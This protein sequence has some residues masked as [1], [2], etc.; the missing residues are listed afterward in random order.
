V[1]VLHLFLPMPSFTDA[2]MPL[3]PAA[4]IQTGE[5]DHTL[6]SHLS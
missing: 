4:K 1:N 2:L 6:A 5:A 3:M